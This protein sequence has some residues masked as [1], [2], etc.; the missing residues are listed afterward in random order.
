M[1]YEPNN[2]NQIF[3]V[4]PDGNYSSIKV[5]AS[6]YISINSKQNTY[7]VITNEKNKNNTWSK[8]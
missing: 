7:E 8:Q 6:N 5:D 3:S 2:Y 1:K 4:I